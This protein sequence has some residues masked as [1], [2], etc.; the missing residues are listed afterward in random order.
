MVATTMQL[1]YRSL[2]VGSVFCILAQPLL[3]A[4]DCA[5]D[6]EQPGSPNSDR[7][8]IDISVTIQPKLPSWDKTEGLGQH[9]SHVERQDKGGLATV[10]KVDL[11]VHTGTHFDAPSHFLQ[12]AF[13]TGVGIE[14]ADLAVL[15]GKYTT[16]VLLYILVLVSCFNANS[17]MLYRTLSCPRYPS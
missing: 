16:H 2:T 1:A 12:E 8:L 3:A 9:R 11:V 13:E 6:P 4:S 14:Q 10:S 7:R 5:W 17:C 15:N